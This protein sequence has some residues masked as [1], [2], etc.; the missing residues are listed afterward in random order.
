MIFEIVWS[1]A[2]LE[3]C[4]QTS[5]LLKMDT[6]KKFFEKALQ[7]LIFFSEKNGKFFLV[8]FLEKLEHKETTYNAGFECTV[9]MKKK[10]QRRVIM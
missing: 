5:P 10:L 1:L 8:L 2:I 7:T 6:A 9:K 4:L 3:Q